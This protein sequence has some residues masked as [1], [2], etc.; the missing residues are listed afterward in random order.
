MTS[1]TQS[2]P[3]VY[4]LIQDNAPHDIAVYLYRL[5]TARCEVCGW[6]RLGRLACPHIMAVREKGGQP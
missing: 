1:I 5:G 6:F 2:A 4:K 3:G